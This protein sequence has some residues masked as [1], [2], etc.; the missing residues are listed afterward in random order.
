VPRLPAPSDKLVLFFADLVGTVNELAS[1]ICGRFLTVWTFETHAIGWQIGLI[2]KKINPRV[3]IA[4]SYSLFGNH[5]VGE[6]FFTVRAFEN[7][8][9]HRKFLMLE[10]TAGGASSP[11]IQANP[12]SGT[13]E[14]N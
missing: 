5:A 13:L 8:S 10:E 4:R 11:M 7:P 1:L 6:I 9:G 2:E 14:M 12:T 3:K